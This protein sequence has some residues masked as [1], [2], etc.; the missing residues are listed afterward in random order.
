MLILTSETNSVNSQNSTFL[1]LES[2]VIAD[3]ATKIANFNLLTFLVL[4]FNEN[5]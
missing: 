2:T 1:F 5:F 3:A 4:N